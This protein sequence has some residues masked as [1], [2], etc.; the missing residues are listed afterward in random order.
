MKRSVIRLIP[1]DSD[2]ASD[3]LQKA[4]HVLDTKAL[5]TQR[6][7][8]QNRNNQRAHR[9]SPVQCPNLAELIER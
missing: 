5:V 9:K 4:D 3:D 8:L 7:R 1:S 2:K 6:R